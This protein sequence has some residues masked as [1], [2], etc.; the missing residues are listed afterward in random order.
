VLSRRGRQPREASSWSGVERSSIELGKRSSHS[1]PN[2]H[3]TRGAGLR[4][5]P[6]EDTDTRAEDALTVAGVLGWLLGYE[7]SY[8]EYG[9]DRKD[10]RMKQKQVLLTKKGGP[11]VLEVV[12]SEVP[13]PGPGEVRVK[14]LATGVAFA[15]V[16]MRHGLYPGVPNFPFTPGYDLVGEVEDLGP[17]VSGLAVGRESRRSPRSAPMPNT[18]PCQRGNSSACRLASTRPR[19][20]ACP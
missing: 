18:S 20:R 7:A 14:V 19:R 13:E 12:E 10:A 3:S 2:R 4:E 8:P 17:G 11:E 5:R 9:D 1:Y 15:D 6:A 16:M